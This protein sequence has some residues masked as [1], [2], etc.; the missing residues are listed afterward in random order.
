MVKDIDDIDMEIVNLESK[1][2]PIF[3]D[4]QIEF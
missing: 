4:F 2:Y 1:N 3:M